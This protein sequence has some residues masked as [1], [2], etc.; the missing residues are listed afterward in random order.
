MS[1]ARA[2]QAVLPSWT[3]TDRDLAA[4]LGCEPARIAGERYR[5]SHA[6]PKERR[7]WADRVVATPEL[8]SQPATLL[9]AKARARTPAGEMPAALAA[10]RSQARSVECPVC[11]S[12]VGSECRD[13]PGEGFDLGVHL[14][15]RAVAGLPPTPSVAV[16]NTGVRPQIVNG[17]WAWTAP[18]TP[19]R[20]GAK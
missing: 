15:R 10:M 3:G 12:D 16:L 5:M 11:G 18:R 17:A 4:K 19:L 6:A 8:A 2:I 20:T 14:A 9:R 13:V 1:L 7:T